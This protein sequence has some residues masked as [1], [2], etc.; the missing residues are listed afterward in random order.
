MR[1]QQERQGRRGTV[2]EDLQESAEG[3]WELGSQ[4]G[5]RGALMQCAHTVAERTLLLTI[6]SRP[7]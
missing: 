6:P 4:A 7:A 5:P 2:Q 3:G 1:E